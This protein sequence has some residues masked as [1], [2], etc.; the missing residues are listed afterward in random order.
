M[1]EANRSPFGEALYQEVS[2]I[3]DVVAPIIESSL[4]RSRIKSAICELIHA[5]V[6]NA[7]TEVAG[8][9]ALYVRGRMR[10][11]RRHY[12]NLGALFTT[13]T[14][15]PGEYE[16]I[17]N[18]L[19]GAAA[20][21]L[22]VDPNDSVRKDW[23]RAWDEHWRKEWPAEGNVPAKLVRGS[24]G[25]NRRRQRELDHSS[26]EFL[27][28]RH[29]LG[30]IKEFRL[31]TQLGEPYSLP[32]A[33]AAASCLSKLVPD[34][35]PAR[36]TTGRA[37]I[38]EHKLPKDSDDALRM[39]RANE[40]AFLSFQDMI[41]QRIEAHCLMVQNSGFGFLAEV[42]NDIENAMTE[43]WMNTRDTLGM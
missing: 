28:D 19:E 6:E 35:D 43:I 14:Y 1:V 41:H 17:K 38:Q 10:I 24:Y 12:L 40:P 31:I 33:Q 9:H 4:L 34:L 18:A 5:A 8:K 11:N 25:I 2:K 3:G 29:Q 32:L 20:A 39:R 13:R 26:W 23:R 16:V 36:L 37:S 21:A 30:W 42:R 7:I 22:R 15:E 27:R